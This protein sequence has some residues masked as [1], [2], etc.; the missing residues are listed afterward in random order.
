MVGWWWRASAQDS[1]WTYE[2][3]PPRSASVMG[4][5]G[6]RVIS[7]FAILASLTGIA[8]SQGWA[9]DSDLQPLRPPYEPPP[10][11]AEML[12]TDDVSSLVGQR[13]VLLSEGPPERRLFQSDAA[14]V[15]EVR[16][17]LIAGGWTRQWISL[18]SQVRQTVTL[19][20]YR[21]TESAVGL[22][23]QCRVDQDLPSDS[24]VVSLGVYLDER[25]PVGGC[26]HA[27]VGRV[28]VE[29]EVALP[30]DSTAADYGAMLNRVVADQSGLIAVTP[31]APSDRMSDGGTFRL[32][33]T[34]TAILRGWMIGLL[35]IA[36][37]AV[38]PTVIADRSGRERLRSHLSRHIPRRRQIDVERDA[39]ARLAMVRATG[40]LRFAALVWALRLT[41]IAFLGA[42]Q[43][44]GVLLA[45]FVGGLVAEHRIQLWGE[46]LPL[47]LMTTRRS[48]VTVAFGAAGSLGIMALAAGLWMFGV[49]LE[50][51]GSLVAVMPE[52]RV[53]RFGQ[54]LQGAAILVLVWSFAPLALARRLAMRHLRNAD[55]S[56]SG[57]V[58]LYLRSFVDDHVRIGARSLGRRSLVDRLA[59]RRWE[60]FEQVAVFE[61]S[62]QG[63]VLAVGT[64]GEVLPPELGAVRIQFSHEEWQQR[65]SELTDKARFI[66]L[67]LGRSEGLVW[68]IRRIRDLGYLHKTVMLVPPV[69]RR[70]RRRRLA[71]LADQ[72]DL[73]WEAVDTGGR[74]RTVLA[75]CFPLGS[76]TPLTVVSRGPDDIS[77][78]RAIHTCVERLE[79]WDAQEPDLMDEVEVAEASPR[80][81]IDQPIPL[82]VPA[83][84]SSKPGGWKR[85]VWVW[86]AALN[87]FGL[88]LL[89]P[90]MLGDPVG[91]QEHTRDLAQWVYSEEI[92]VIAGSHDGRVQLLADGAVL[93]SFSID[94]GSAVRVLTV[95]DVVSDAQ[96]DGDV[97]YYVSARSGMVGCVDLRERTVLWTTDLGPGVRGMSIHD[98]EVAI[99]Q[100]VSGEI[101][102]MDA[103]TGTVRWRVDSGG[104]VWDTAANAERLYA[105][106]L[107]TNELLE[108]DP[109]TREV[110]HRTAVAAAPVAVVLWNDAVVIQSYVEHAVVLATSQGVHTFLTPG[111][112]PALAA[113]EDLLVM[114]GHERLTVLN[115]S[116]E[117]IRY[118]T[119]STSKMHLDV[120]GET[121]TFYDEG[122]IQQ[123]VVPE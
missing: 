4:T 28:T 12:D 71:V 78:A 70:E 34:R 35:T 109:R 105:V 117:L 65:V 26:A 21:M 23:D 14:L 112:E 94:D 73:T 59:L 24:E 10:L 107:D 19:V 45:V 57:S 20:E 97:L 72:L 9:R 114:Q 92:T 7:L 56:A 50:P 6:W 99:A 46:R 76:V 102:V 95:P 84:R 17:I 16:E 115:T 77:Y 93:A 36:A 63:T 118:Q 64:P 25:N 90:W 116:G 111:N 91:S 80:Y 53:T 81:G 55:V 60:R 122:A 31:D 89:L 98:D 62:R 69:A 1:E 83:G 96:I 30:P 40:W 110:L 47:N 51:V 106:V 44:I 120:T 11:V 121:V 100:P 18:D 123:V 79:S 29:V 15:M 48:R 5:R 86:N 52:W 42:W 68:E 101:I 38:I 74:G 27:V 85:N 54:G 108:I 33:A 37:I 61:A 3:G 41:E 87:G 113:S 58:V 2:H 66:F 22:E 49:N 32:S 104:A 67:T 103:A 13:M 119:A 82:V 8:T 43:T 75:V 39:A 88:S